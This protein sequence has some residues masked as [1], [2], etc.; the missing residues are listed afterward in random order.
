MALSEAHYNNEQKPHKTDVIPLVHPENSPILNSIL[1]GEEPSTSFSV[2]DLAHFYQ[3][4]GSQKPL[5]I[6]EEAELLR[7]T[8]VGQD[9]ANRLDKGEYSF[10]HSEKALRQNIVIGDEARNK[11]IVSNLELITSAAERHGTDDERTLMKLIQIGGGALRQAIRFYDSSSGLEFHD[12]AK[13]YI[14]DKLVKVMFN[15]IGNTISSMFQ[16]DY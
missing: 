8:R 4:V 3:D 1:S 2:R 10:K 7:R 12:Y 6:N 9:S 5:T 15:R 13:W 11:L 14:E 16:P